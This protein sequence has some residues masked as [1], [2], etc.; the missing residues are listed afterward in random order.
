MIG[1]YVT[2]LTVSLLHSVLLYRTSV[3]LFVTGIAHRDM[4]PE[5]ILCAVAGQLIPVKICDFDLGSGVHINSRCTSPVTT[6]ELLSPVSIL[7]LISPFLL[8]LQE[9]TNGC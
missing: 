4:K 8:N 3:F 1:F 9:C 7:L 5:N 2:F 6:P